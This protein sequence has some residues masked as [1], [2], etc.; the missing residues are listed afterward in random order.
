MAIYACD[1]TLWQQQAADYAKKIGQQTQSE[2]LKKATDRADAIAE[3]AM[4]QNGIV[5]STELTE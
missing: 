5:V 1:N 3:A 4:A 2:N